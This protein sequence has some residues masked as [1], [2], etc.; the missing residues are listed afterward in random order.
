MK[1][2][3][4]TRISTCLH[5]FARDAPPWIC[6]SI[7]ALPWFMDFPTT[8]VPA[9]CGNWRVAPICSRPRAG[10]QEARVFLWHCGFQL[11]VQKPGRLCRP[12]GACN[13]SS[14]AH[15]DENQRAAKLRHKSRHL[16]VGAACFGRQ[17]DTLRKQLAIARH[18]QDVL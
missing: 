9:V 12:V 4:K 2:Y 11:K 6:C 16:P 8:L 3:Q 17:Q 7:D 15:L 5:V 10:K 14:R 13:S 1:V 18:T